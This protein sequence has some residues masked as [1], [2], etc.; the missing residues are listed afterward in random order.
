MCVYIYIY[1]YGIYVCIQRESL[2]CAP[3]A[4]LGLLQRRGR[5]L[6]RTSTSEN[7]IT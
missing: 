6:Q 1:M 3:E 5:L 2:E 7:L 4:C